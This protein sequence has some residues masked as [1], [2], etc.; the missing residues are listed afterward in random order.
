[1]STVTIPRELAQSLLVLMT[2][3]VTEGVESV[4]AGQWLTFANALDK[5]MH[6]PPA[7]QN[8]PGS[9]PGGN[10]LPGAC[11]F[12]QAVVGG[13]TGLCAQCA[14][15]LLRDASELEQS[16]HACPRCHDA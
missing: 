1:M 15:D 7:S 2:R 9:T 12:C 3:S 5:A 4:P 16:K 10:P 14:D 13:A 11:R 8:A 6:A